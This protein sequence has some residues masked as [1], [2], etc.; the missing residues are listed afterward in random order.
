MR[1]T[2]KPIFKLFTPSQKDGIAVHSP[3]DDNKD[4]RVLFDWINNNM[5]A[6]DVDPDGI[7]QM[8]VTNIGYNNFVGRL[9]IG[10]VRAGKLKLGQQ[11]C[12]QPKKD[13]L[14]SK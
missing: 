9:A 1:L 2:N 12:R 5:P 10:R 4:L 11:V 8:M 7:L 3:G 6:P 13:Q 14:N